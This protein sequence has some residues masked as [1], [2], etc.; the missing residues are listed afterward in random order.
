MNHY[1]IN[2][3]TASRA[4]RFDLMAHAVEVT[5][6]ITGELMEMA[7]NIGDAVNDAMHALGWRDGAC[8]ECAVRYAACLHG[9]H[10][11]DQAREMEVAL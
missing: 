8:P 10:H 1:T 6:P 5:E 7:E 3:I 9:E 2:A 11:A 4:C